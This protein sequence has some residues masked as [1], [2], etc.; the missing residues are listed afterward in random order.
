MFRITG[1]S[2]PISEIQ[3]LSQEL[4]EAELFANK[5]NISLEK[6]PIN[7]SNIDIL[8]LGKILDGSGDINIFLL[9]MK[10]KIP[11]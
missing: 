6:K 7:S 3:H 1:S 10:Q 5:L 2:L 11:F 4:I 8:K 9:F